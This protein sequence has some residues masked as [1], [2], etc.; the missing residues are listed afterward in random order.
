MFFTEE[1]YRKIEKWF[2]HRAIRDTQFPPANP[3]T[4]E[5][6]IALIQEGENRT[7]PLQ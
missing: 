5:E 2:S 7:T 3:L 6:L 1:D 4:G